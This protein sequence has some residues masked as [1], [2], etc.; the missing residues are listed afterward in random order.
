MF[1]R[2][3]KKRDGWLAIIGS[4]WHRQYS[5]GQLL[6]F[7]EAWLCQKRIIS[8][9]LERMTSVIETQSIVWEEG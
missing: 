9:W 4:H 3:D 2:G 1:R 8:P 5:C 6:C 7:G